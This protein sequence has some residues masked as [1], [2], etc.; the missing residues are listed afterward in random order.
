MLIIFFTRQLIHKEPNVH[1]EILGTYFFFVAL[2]AIEKRMPRLARVPTL[3]AS[4]PLLNAGEPVIE[5]LR[6]CA[7][8]FIYTHKI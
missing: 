7:V 8:I 6:M 4:P 3:N 5:P 1:S 2:L